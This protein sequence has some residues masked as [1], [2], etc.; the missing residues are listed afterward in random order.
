M[1]IAREGLHVARTGTGFSGLPPDDLPKPVADAAII[2]RECIELR[3]AK[4]G[5]LLEGF[6]GVKGSG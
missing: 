6:L 2:A 3:E 5:K 4:T 1:E